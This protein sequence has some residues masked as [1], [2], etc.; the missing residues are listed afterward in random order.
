M[1]HT[2]HSCFTKEKDSCFTKEKDDLEIEN[3]KQLASNNDKICG[4]FD[5]QEPC[6]YNT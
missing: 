5:L 4:L 6:I 3:D 1:F 2:L